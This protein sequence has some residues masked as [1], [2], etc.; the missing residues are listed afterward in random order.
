MRGRL[1]HAKSTAIVIKWYC[2]NYRDRL[3]EVTKE[4]MRIIIARGLTQQ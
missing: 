2:K 4:I 3:L 1:V